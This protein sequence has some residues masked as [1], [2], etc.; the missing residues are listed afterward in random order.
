[1]NFASDISSDIALAKPE[2]GSKRKNANERIQERYIAAIVRVPLKKLIFIGVFRSRRKDSL[3]LRQS[4]SSSSES[5]IHPPIFSEGHL[6]P[7]QSW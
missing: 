6:T 3:S 5:L 4:L 7:V 2:K 1:M